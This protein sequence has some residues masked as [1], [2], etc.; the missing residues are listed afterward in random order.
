MT[1]RPAPTSVGVGST[2]IRPSPPIRSRSRSPR[3]AAGTQYRTSAA[4][5]RQPS[6]TPSRVGRSRCH[7]GPGGARRPAARRVRL[8]RRVPRRPARGRPSTRRTRPAVLA[9]ALRPVARRPL[10]VSNGASTSDLGR[11]EGGLGAGLPLL[12]GQAHPHAR[13]GQL[14]RRLSAQVGRRSGRGPVRWSGRST[15]GVPV[16][17]GPRTGPY[18]RP[19]LQVVEV[20]LHTERQRVRVEPLRPGRAAPLLRLALLRRGHVARR[21]GPRGL[22]RVPRPPGTA[23]A[24]AVL[25]I[26]YSLGAAIATITARLEISATPAP[27]SPMRRQQDHRRGRAPARTTGPAARRVRTVRLWARSTAKYVS[28][29]TRST[30]PTANQRSS[31]V[32]ASAYPWPNTPQD[33]RRPEEQHSRPPAA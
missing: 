21:P 4:A 24:G 2:E 18:V 32:A 19:P 30:A 25:T 16:G 23:S 12:D 29:T 6:S 3:P 27:V 11:A 26:R 31:G 14:E 10:D 28:M 9:Y 8:T 5:S 17:R 7:A 13:S 33:P 1:S 22:R 15:Y 20:Q